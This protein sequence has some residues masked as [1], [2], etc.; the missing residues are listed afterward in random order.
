MNFYDFHIGDYTSRTAHLDP[1]ED[2]AYRR[3]LDLYYT[4]ETALPADVDQ[5][6]RLIRMRT[7]VQEIKVVLDEFFISNGD[8][9]WLHT[10]CEEVIA[11][12]NAKRA[13][14]KKSA[15]ARWSKSDPDANAMRTHSDRID[16]AKPSQCDG[17]A[18]SPSP[19]PI[20]TTDVVVAPQSD[21]PKPKRGT[22][23]PDDWFLPQPWGQ[24]ALDQFPH[25]TADIVRQEA[26]KFANHW[27]SKTGKDATKRDWLATW[28]NWCMSDICQRTHPPPGQSTET[29]Y[30]RQMRERV[31][32]A[33]GSLAHIVAAKPPGQPFKPPPTPWD[34][35]IENQRRAATT[36]VGGCDLLETVSDIRP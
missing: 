20:T 33:A 28:K 34:V 24:W 29:P 11:A 13:S 30:A 1:L 2:L 9:G 16:S 10:K 7:N 18:P 17:N 23:L 8:A 14:A 6:A 12:A 32:E 36:G 4:R 3:M 19:S 26:L 21:A 5:I 27:H 15:D 22:R 31:A 35:A 25:F